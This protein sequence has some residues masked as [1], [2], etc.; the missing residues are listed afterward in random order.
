MRNDFIH[1]FMRWL[2]VW[3][4]IIAIFTGFGNMPL[5]KR[6]YI[7]DIPGMQWSGDFF[8]NMMVHYVAGAFVL[9]TSIYFAIAFIAS[10]RRIKLSASGKVRS[11]FLGLALLS[12]GLMALK[13]LPGIRFDL[14]MHMASNF[15]HLG[16]ALL[17][18]LGSVVA[19]VTR[20]KWVQR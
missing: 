20:S 10:P 9:M 4:A 19:I 2:Y 11:L 12:G 13:N 3:G 17:F 6:Y 14:P 18:F 15:F 5:Y 16:A 1:R 8:L 7:A